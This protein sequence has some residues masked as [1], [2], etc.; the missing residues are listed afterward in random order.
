[1]ILVRGAGFWSALVRLHRVV[2][3]V[4]VWGGWGGGGS[5]AAIFDDLAGYCQT[6]PNGGL[7]VAFRQDPGMISFI[8]LRSPAAGRRMAAHATAIL[9]RTLRGTCVL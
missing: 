5:V 9:P 1:M 2:G 3:N 7:A 8:C 4:C 6:L